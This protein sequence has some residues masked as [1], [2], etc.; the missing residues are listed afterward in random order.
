LLVSR[1]TSTCLPLS[2]PRARFLMFSDCTAERKCCKSSCFF[3]KAGLRFSP[4]FQGLNKAYCLKKWGYGTYIH[5][6]M[7]VYVYTHT[8]MHI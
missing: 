4:I 2:A 3:D 6:Y 8:Y 5:V 7:C 1:H